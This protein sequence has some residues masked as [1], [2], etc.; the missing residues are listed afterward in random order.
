[1]QEN[2]NHSTHH[3]AATSS[4]ASELLL[5]NLQLLARA[6]F[7][8]M[9]IVCSFLFTSALA[10]SACEPMDEEVSSLSAAVTTPVEL[11]DDPVYEE[12]A[13]KAVALTQR[14]TSDTA[15]LSATQLDAKLA[16]LNQLLVALEDA[17]SVPPQFWQRTGI[18]PA[19]LQAMTSR[20]AQVVEGHPEL[21]QVADSPAFYGEANDS[22]VQISAAQSSDDKVMIAGSD[23]CEGECENAYNKETDMATAVYIGEGLICIL[24][25]AA[26]PIAY[27]VCIA[28]A[29]TKMAIAITNAERHRE[30]C[31]AVCNGEDPSN[32]CYTDS[33][34]PSSDFCFKGTLTIGANSC[35]EKKE[36]G[37]VCSR[38]GKCKSGCCKYNFWAN[39]VSMVCRPASKCD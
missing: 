30:D 33:D 17:D 28:A 31:I 24:S 15:G 21:A 18:T 16:D 26:G 10:L 13:L 14:M 11:A 20:F 36:E 1:M 39:P 22:N 12:L 7:T 8:V 25:G 35:K 9:F 4:R 29:T 27:A 19:Q 23:A 5:S 2:K 32:E 34:C 38:D 3:L 6:K 37:K